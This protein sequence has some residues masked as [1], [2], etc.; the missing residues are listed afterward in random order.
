MPIAEPGNLIIE[1]TVTEGT[2]AV[3]LDSKPGYRRFGDHYTTGTSGIPYSIEHANGVREVGL[4]TYTLVGSTHTLARNQ[5]L[6]NDINTTDLRT[7]PAGE[8]TVSIPLLGKYTAL[9]DRA[10]TWTQ[11]Q[12]IAN[13][14]RLYFGDASNSTSYLHSNNSP[15]ILIFVADAEE[16]IRFD[17]VSGRLRVRDVDSSVGDGPELRLLRAN[18]SP[19]DNMDIGVVRWTFLDDSGA[20]VTAGKIRWWV[21]DVSASTVDTRFSIETTTA[22]AATTVIGSN[23]GVFYVAAGNKLLVGSKT[24]SAPGTAG[25]EAHETGKTWITVSGDT[26]LVVNRLTN[27]GTLIDFQQAGTSEG[28]ISVAGTTVSLVGAVLAHDSAWADGLPPPLQYGMVLETADERLEPGDHHP[29]VRLAQ[30]GSRRVYG[31]FAQFL[32]EHRLRVYGAGATECLVKGPVHGGDLL[33]VSDEPGIATAQE[34]DILRSSTVAKVTVGDSETGTRLV[35]V[36]RN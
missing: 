17:G 4:G 7:L 16:L 3:T 28:S 35:P 32:P 21:P 5:V 24:A 12:R 9:L 33:C 34:D 22:G 36:D 6:A 13:A 2:S 26:P 30:P 14:I 10:Q 1:T 31:M 19:V 20:E 8:K 11:H 23:T 18:P 27:D 15:N 25:F 29:R